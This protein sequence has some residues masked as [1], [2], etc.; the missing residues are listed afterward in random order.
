M[1]RQKH[2]SGPSSYN[3][4]DFLFQCWHV[5]LHV[6]E[7]PAARQPQ[8]LTMLSRTEL[9]CYS[10]Q[11]Q[12]RYHPPLCM[13]QYLR[14]S[15]QK[16]SP[17]TPTLTGFKN[18]SRKYPTWKIKMRHST[19]LRYAETNYAWLEDR[20]ED[21]KNRSCR[22]NLRL[23]GLSESVTMKGLHNIC[24]SELLHALGLGWSCRVKLA[25]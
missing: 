6:R 4:K 16:P 5:E 8:P 20:L 21:L 18:L 10:T 19:K 2:Y 23:E 7:V 24:E 9:I 17:G 1:N 22:N 15:G 11:Q 3:I 13:E 12:V 25:H 14:C